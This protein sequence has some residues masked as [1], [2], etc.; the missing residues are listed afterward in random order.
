[1]CGARKRSRRRL[2]VRDAG[3]FL[4][5]CYG[6]EVGGNVE[7]DPHGEFQGQEHFVPGA[8]Y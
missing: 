4:R 5:S 7:E 1:M 3:D 6:V 8:F 2:G